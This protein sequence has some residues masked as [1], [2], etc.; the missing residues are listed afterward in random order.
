MLFSLVKQFQR[1]LQ[2]RNFLRLRTAFGEN[3]VQWFD[4]IKRV[5]FVA[6]KLA[7]PYSRRVEKSLSKCFLLLTIFRWS[8]NDWNA[9]EFL[10]AL[11][12]FDLELSQLFLQIV[13]GVMNNPVFSK[14]IKEARILCKEGECQGMYMTLHVIDLLVAM[15]AENPSQIG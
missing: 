14:K 12:Q 5:L 3:F 10:Q 2:G 8:Q 6:K 15:A 4:I 9:R 11:Q 7:Y 13:T 1:G